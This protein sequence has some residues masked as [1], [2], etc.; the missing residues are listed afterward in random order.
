MGKNL[1]N[2]LNQKKNLK[3]FN[4]ISNTF[5]NENTFNINK[6]KILGGHICRYDH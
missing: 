5:L 4:L 3:R 2:N 1:Q 6:K